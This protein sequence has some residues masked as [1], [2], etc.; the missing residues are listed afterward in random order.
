MV[1]LVEVIL[2][3]PLKQT[4]TYS[5]RKEEAHFIK[6]GMRV[7]VPFGK[8]KIY[9]GIAYKVVYGEAPTYSIKSIDHILDETPIITPEQIRHWEW[10]SSYYMCTLGEIVKAALPSAFLLQ[11]ET[12]LTLHSDYKESQH[13]PNDEALLLIQALEYQSE[14]H[15]NDA[16]TILEQKN[17][18]HLVNSLIE[19]NII[20]VKEEV[21]E[22][23]TPKLKR[24]IKLKEDLQE[25]Q[26]LKEVLTSFNRAPKQKLALMSLFV[27][28]SKSKEPVDVL[29]F[30]KKENISS[31]IIKALL[32]K[33]VIEEYFVQY[34]RV[35][36]SNEPQQLRSTLNEAQQKGFVSII[37]QFEQQDCVLLHGVTSSGKTEIYAKLIAKYLELGKQVLF[38]VPEIALTTQLIGRFKKYFGTYVSVYHSNY[39]VSERV[40]VWNNLVNNKQ[41]AQLII[42]ARS[43][44]LLPFS[45]LG[46]VI[47]D[48]EHEP[49]YKQ[50]NPS[51]RYHGRDAAIVLSK[52]HKAKVLLG[53][54]TPSIESYFNSQENKYGLVE[55]K[56]RYANIIPPDI[57]LVDIKEKY[58]KKEMQYHFSDTLISAIQE[59]LSQ[60]EQVL[61]FQNRR[62]YSPIIECL[63][64][65]VSP[66]CPNCDVS[67]TYHQY[68]NSLLCHYC[69]YKEAMPNTC[70]ACN[71]TTLDTKGFG[72]EQIEKEARLLFP[73]KTIVRVDQDT[74][75]GKHA[76]EKIIQEVENGTVDILVGTQMLAKGLD[77]RNITL[78]GVLNADNLL[79]FP[80][81]RAHE[82]SFQLLQQV[83]GRSG[84]TKKRGKVLIQTFNPYHQILQQ[85]T[86]NAYKEMYIQQREE[87]YTYKYP[88]FYRTIKITI[89]DRKEVKMD[90]ASKWI[91]QALRIKMD[92]SVLGPQ[93]PPVAR[94][95]NLYLSNVLLK[96]PK[97]GSLSYYKNYI[98]TVLQKFYAIKE[99]SSVKIT[100]D[101]DNY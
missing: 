77:F 21:Y 64:C 3:I 36:F 83:A 24:Y 29:A 72:T 69:N 51:P 99:F 84:R 5:V 66:Q 7:A 93:I 28:A 15:L 79:N 61:L 92:Q 98:A 56:H 81:F 59:A 74:T 39:S 86:T 49:S 47:V 44:V 50:Y 60:E 57:T 96:L 33:E 9:T 68:K 46:L 95:R 55:L 23:Y 13:I 38:M 101:V 85:V 90:K 31:A 27:W 65:G 19:A 1:Y 54:A 58:R 10:M 76:Y 75:K 71:A 40:E 48:E 52:F 14:L 94:I 88:P 32:T 41:K 45:K 22:K 37:N 80:D 62:G 73:S 53:S 18:V 16:R 35:D 6:Q 26:K 87:R 43:S 89:K 70:K 42:G 4:F 63:S 67:L 91:A 8:S 82:R 20:V 2:P 25:E 34:D 12:I 17:I 78:V 100:I 30:Q 97:K 11:S